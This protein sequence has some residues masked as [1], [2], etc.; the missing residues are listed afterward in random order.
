M[1]MRVT[2]AFA[3]LVTVFVSGVPLHGG[4]IPEP[5]VV[6]AARRGDVSALRELIAQGDALRDSIGQADTTAKMAYAVFDAPHVPAGSG[7]SSPADVSDLEDIP[8][9]L[10]NQVVARTC[11]TCHNDQLRTGNLSLAGFDVGAAAETAETAE[12]MIRKLRTEMMP[13]PGMPRP[14]GDTLLA[15]V[16]TLEEV[17]DEAAA[18]N[19]NPGTRGFQRLN[20]AEYEKA[21]ADLLGL[22]VD[23]GA[24]LPEDTY[25]ANF[26]NMAA[27]QQMSTTMLNAYVNAANEVARFALGHRSAVPTPTTYTVSALVSQHSWDRLEGA[28]IGSR[29]GLVA[30][31]FFPA[32]GEYVF[33]MAFFQGDQ[34]RDEVLDISIDGEEAT[35]LM[36][37]VLERD[38]DH[39]PN[40]TMRSNPVFVRTG[41]HRV[42]VTFVRRGDGP[43]FDVL[44]PHDWSNAGTRQPV[45][46]G[47]TALPHLRWVTITGPFNPQGVSETPSRQ[48]LLTCRPMSAAEVRSCGEQ[49]VRRLGLRA[50]RR[51][52]TDEDEREL[53]SFFDQGVAEGGFEVGVRTALEAVL[54]SP[55]FV[56]RVERQPPDVRPGQ[57]YLL[58]D[59][60]LASRL[61]F[62]LWGAPPDAELVQLASQ[63]RLRDPKILEAQARRLLSDPRGADALA[64]RF[65]AQWLRLQDLDKMQPDAYWFPNYTEQLASDM[66]RETQLFFA[67]LVREDRSV[68]ELYNADYTFVN[69]RLA[70]HYGISG[71]VG[72]EFRR[73]EYPDET[74]RGL[75]GHGSVLVETSLG[76]RTSPVLRGKWVMEVLLGTPPPPPPPGTPDLEETASTEGGRRLTTRERMERHRASPTCNACHQYM[77]PIG[78]ALDNFD[79]TGKWRIREN[80]MP[81]DTRGN[82]YDGTPISS[83]SDLTQTLLRRPIALLRNFTDNLLAYA[84]GRQVEYYDQPA[85]RAIVREAEENDYRLSSFVVSVVKSDAFRKGKAALETAEASGN[86]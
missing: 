67:N 21:I 9:D 39:G 77:D 20:R 74:R 82:F 8:F 25:L 28:P 18:E 45:S 34:S 75:L 35:Q 53:M 12:K 65:A 71:V 23:A 31:H 57:S 46:Y 41:Q 27:T 79:V 5:P 48:R 68:L 49:I 30:D 19:P 1:R 56:F 3:L 10:L 86:Q 24:W 7:V 62:F 76:N 55:H 70:K 17:I 33:D 78:L 50:Y 15:L 44:E 69:E 2:V 52:L 54:A 38:A 37:E 29:G 32:D 43:Y 40:W 61:S 51:P 14:G 84:I 73:I 72:D 60:E 83:P 16:T 36:V 13:P 22:E 80:G 42:A 81:L 59:T 11:Q 47:A 58:G 64:T 85:V 4:W 26:D 63:G 66:R 6:E